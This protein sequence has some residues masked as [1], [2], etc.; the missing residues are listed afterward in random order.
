MAQIAGNST[1]RDR[2]PVDFYPTP[3]SATLAL[4]HCVQLSH[5]VWEPACGKLDISRVLEANGHT[6]K[7]T[8]IV[9]GTDFFDCHY[10]V[11][12]DIVTNP[13]FS[14]GLKFVEHALKLTS[15]RV[16][17]LLPIGFMTSASRNHLMTS[18]RLEKAIVLA[19]RLKI[20]TH[21][22]KVS[23]QFNHVW[24]IFNKSHTGPAILEFA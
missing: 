16:C 5:D 1:D 19:K 8:D 18:G 12:C 3:E 15:G 20:E 24:Y 17:M 22:G 21:Y 6:V 2:H 4:L 9:F 11:S 14:M 10:E 7:S 13:P 23:S